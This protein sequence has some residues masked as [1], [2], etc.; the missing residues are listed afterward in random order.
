MFDFAKCLIFGPKSAK[1][2][3]KRFKDTIKNEYNSS[4]SYDFGDL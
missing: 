2:V 4:E 1:A 3:F